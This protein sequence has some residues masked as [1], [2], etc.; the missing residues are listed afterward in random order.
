MSRVKR[1][2][3]NT[4]KLVVTQLKGF[5]KAGMSGFLG[6]KTKVLMRYLDETLLDQIIQ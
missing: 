4:S 1:W 6:T 2:N 5:V 3:L